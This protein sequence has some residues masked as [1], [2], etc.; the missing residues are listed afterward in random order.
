M[1]ATK[2]KL[3][4]LNINNELTIDTD[5]DKEKMEFWDNLYTKY[6]K[7][8][9]Q[10]L[11]NDDDML[12]SEPIV[13]KSEPV[14]PKS[15]P[16]SPQNESISPQKES[17]SP[18]HEPISPKT[19]P[20]IVA[21]SPVI[22]EETIIT[23]VT[24]VVNEKGEE[25][26]NT[27]VLV[28]VQDSTGQHYQE[29][30]NDSKGV[31]E[32]VSLVQDNLIQVN[33]N[34]TQVPDNLSQVPDNLT[35]VPDNLSQVPDKSKTEVFVVDNPVKP[36]VISGHTYI[37]DLPEKLVNIVKLQEKFSNNNQNGDEHKFN[38]N[39]DRKPRPSNEIK[40]VQ[41]SNINP[42]DVIRANDPPEDDLP[43]NIGVN[44]FVNFFE[45]LGGKK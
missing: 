43:K 7:I 5:P 20:V 26:T 12:N 30:F 6:F 35:Q 9:D 3:Y 23:T 29:S 24:T 22:V 25:K 45:S 39:F 21:T 4:Y 14:S 28:D 10:Q 36:D 32:Q 16:F 2:D 34:L 15:E 44:K 13:P 27:E 31:L 40:M 33:D 17:I 18:Q 8:W 1:P 19:E 42:K 38:G 41:N 11:N 37:E